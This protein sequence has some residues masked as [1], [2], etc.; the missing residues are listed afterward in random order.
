MGDNGVEGYVYAYE[1]IGES[2]ASPEEAVALMKRREE[3]GETSK[4]I[5]VYDS[6][7]ENVIDTFT[8]KSY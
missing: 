6:E 5:S 8:I 4:V 7:G 1:L 2:S 3:T